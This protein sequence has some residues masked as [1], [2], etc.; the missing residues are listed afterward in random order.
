MQELTGLLLVCVQVV[1]EVF[2]TNTGADSDGLL[3]RVQCDRVHILDRDNDGIFGSTQIT[4]SVAGILCQEPMP[5][6]LSIAHLRA[7]I[8]G[9]SNK[10][11]TKS[12]GAFNPFIHKQKT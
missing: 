7:H 11:N 1:D 10:K 8:T 5:R 12:T 4:E 3:A 9:F 2:G 6:E